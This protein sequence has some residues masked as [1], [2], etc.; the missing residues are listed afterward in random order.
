MISHDINKKTITKRP[1]SP[2]VLA[3]DF[4]NSIGTLASLCQEGEKT[5]SASIL[6][7]KKLNFWWYFRYYIVQIKG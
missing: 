6:T 2:S 3:I 5:E 4:F 1:K 7:V